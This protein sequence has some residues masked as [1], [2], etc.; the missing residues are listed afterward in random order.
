MDS[1]G[2]ELVDEIATQLVPE[3]WMLVGGLMVHAHARITGV[4][5]ARVTDDADIVVE[6]GV[7]GRYREAVDALAR[8]GFRPY[9]S[10]DDRA[11]TYRFTRGRQHVDLMASDRSVAPKHLGRAVLQVPGSGSA[12]KRTKDFVTPAGSMIRI[13]DVCGALSLKGAAY[14]LPSPHPIRHLQDAVVLL[15]CLD[16]RGVEPPS[17][18]MRSNINRLLVGLDTRPEAWSLA[19]ADTVRRAIRGVRVHLRPDWDPPSF[20]FPQ[21]F[22]GRRPTAG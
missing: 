10:L 3:R 21:R 7:A 18:S 9:E 17:K 12:L 22:R 14:G 5:H 2:F 19:S 16:A 6:L 1:D 8:L 20:A 4:P 11:P 15:A 13:P